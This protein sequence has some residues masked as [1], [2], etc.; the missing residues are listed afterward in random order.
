MGV[1]LFTQRRFMLCPSNYFA[2]FAMRLWGA[3]PWMPK[4]SGVF[5]FLAQI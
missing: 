1:L 5:T 2:S 3:G 4:A